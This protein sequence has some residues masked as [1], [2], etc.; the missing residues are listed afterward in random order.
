MKEVCEPGTT[1]VNK[2]GTWRIFRPV[3]NTEKCMGCGRCSMFCPDGV[4]NVNPETRKAEV[5]YDYC[6]GCG[7]CSKVCPFGAISMEREKK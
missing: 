5:N 6:K 4:I 7:I 3:V 2:T 1:I